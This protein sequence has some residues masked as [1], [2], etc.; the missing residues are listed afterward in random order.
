LRIASRILNLYNV[1]A[2]T[3]AGEEEISMFASIIAFGRLSRAFAIAAGLAALTAGAAFACDC[4]YHGDYYRYHHEGAGNYSCYG[5][6]HDCRYE[7]DRG[8][9]YH[10]VYRG[11]YR[12]D[13][14]RYDQ[15]YR[16]YDRGYRGW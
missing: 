9:Y 16:H 10:D 1:F 12:Y 15:R 6:F 3:A 13:G 2:L 7:G 4:G 14:H 11:G 5:G 8:G